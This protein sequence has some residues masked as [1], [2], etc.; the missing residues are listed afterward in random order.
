MDTA[1][2]NVD[3]KARERLE[4]RDDNKPPESTNN[5]TSN[6]NATIAKSLAG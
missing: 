1:I 4:Q 2:S 5:T 3:Q 6:A